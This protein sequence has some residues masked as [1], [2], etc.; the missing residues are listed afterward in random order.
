[1]E[2]LRAF[3]RE[4][5]KSKYAEEASKLLAEGERR[6]AAHEWYVAQ[7]YW[8]RQ[9]WAGVTGR[10]E[11]ILKTWPGNAREPE[12]LL[13]LAQAY[14]KLDEKH[15]AQQALQKLI[16]RHPQD[17]RRPEAEKLLARLR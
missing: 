10:L 13:M 17:P 9:R 16:A 15:L 4:R 7:F 2:R 12:A 11:G 5:P 6:L 14:A 1:V 8:D 3:A